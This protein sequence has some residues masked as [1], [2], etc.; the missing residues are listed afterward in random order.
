MDNLMALEGRIWLLGDQIDTDLIVPSRVLT[1]QDPQ[2][3]LDATLETVFPDFAHQVQPGDILV[4]G[5][6]F[7]CGSSREEAVFVLKQLGITAIIA[8]SFA[9]IYF[10]NCINL[11]LYPI[12]LVKRGPLG[13]HHDRIRIDFSKG[14][15]ENLSSHTQKK[16]QP[17]PPF[18]RQYLEQGGAITQL[19]NSLTLD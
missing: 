13:A 4:A 8:E 6:N 12:T 16:F 9:R 1:E 14:T 11:G 10:R 5:K 17:Y 19:K 15:I 2:K 3:L 7:G 18:I